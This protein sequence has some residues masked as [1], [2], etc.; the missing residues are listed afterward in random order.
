MGRKKIAITRISDERNRQITF[1]KRKYGLLKKAY[2]LS[3]LCDTEIA[4]MMITNNCKLYQ[5]ASS[6]INEFLMKYTEIQE[7]FESKTNADVWQ[8]VTRK[9]VKGEKDDSDDE[10]ERPQP[11]QAT[12]SVANYEKI[13]EE[14]DQMF[15]HNQNQME[16]LTVN[17]T[18]HNVVA[19]RDSPMTN[20]T[21]LTSLPPTMPVAVPVT[22]DTSKEQPQEQHS[23]RGGGNIFNPMPPPQVPPR[24]QALKNPQLKLHLPGSGRNYI[25]LGSKDSSSP[26]SGSGS[27]GSSSGGELNSASSQSATPVAMGSP[28]SLGKGSKPSLRVVIPASKGSHGKS[29][30][31]QTNPTTNITQYPK[32][33]TASQHNDPL[34]TPIMSLATPSLFSNLPSMMSGLGDFPFNSSTSEQPSALVAIPINLQQSAAATSGNM[35]LQ[36]HNLGQPFLLTPTYEPNAPPVFP[37]PGGSSVQGGSQEILAH[38][39]LQQQQQMQKQSHKVAPKGNDSSTIIEQPTSHGFAQVDNSEQEI[40]F[41]GSIDPSRTTLQSY[42][43][44]LSSSTLELPVTK[45][46]RLT[47]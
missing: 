44:S 15:K 10:A 28:S 41:A 24:I 26:R 43:P 34:A 27:A 5:Y 6:N 32:V 42:D 14:F 45:R 19:T 21:M 33:V 47:S 3:I 35:M 30:M 7:P 22:D 1:S 29:G 38:Y 4:I 8:D 31:V 12:V 17:T 18:T 20:S 11:N 40:S 2:E 16:T 25:K 9:E 13:N 39:L 37:S 46:V 23:G 36:A